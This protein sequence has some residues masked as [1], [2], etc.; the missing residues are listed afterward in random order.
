MEID[1]RERAF[2][3]SHSHSAQRPGMFPPAPSGTDGFV[4]DWLVPAASDVPHLMKNPIIVATFCFYSVVSWGR[5][6]AR[7]VEE[8]EPAAAL[9]AWRLHPRAGWWVITPVM[10]QQRLV[11]LFTGCQFTLP[12]I[13]FQVGAE[14]IHGQAAERRFPHPPLTHFLF[15]LCPYSY[16]LPLIPSWDTDSLSITADGCPMPIHHSG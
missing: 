11:D 1:V 16:T 5:G 4:D 9:W 13:Y 6:I 14:F 3:A 2:P 15:R 10:R 12:L 8:W 7:K